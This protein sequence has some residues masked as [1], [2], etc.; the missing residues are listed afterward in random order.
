MADPCRR[1]SGRCAYT[2]GRPPR[3]AEPARATGPV[4]LPG[5]LGWSLPTAVVIPAIKVNAAV[6]HVRDGADGPAPAPAGEG[7]AGWRVPGPAPGEPGVAVLVGNRHDP[8]GPP[9]GPGVFAR[10]AELRVGAVVGV[11]RAD[12]TV[13]VFRVASARQVPKA[14]F[15]AARSPAEG[16]R[17]ELRLITCAGRYDEAR[18]AYADDLIVYATFAAAYTLADLVGA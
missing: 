11:V 6:A 3:P 4:P 8:A 18:G 13:A 14:A 10:L 5:L 15:T 17:P 7:V 16:E 12:G 2:R 9:S 1:R